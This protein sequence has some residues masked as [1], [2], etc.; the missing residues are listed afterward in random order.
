MPHP[1]SGTSYTYVAARWY[2]PD[3][4]WTVSTQRPPKLGEQTRAVIEE[5]A[6]PGKVPSLSPD[7]GLARGSA[8]AGPT[9]KPFALSGVRVV[10][11]GWMLASAGAGRYLAALG[12]EVI[13]V[14]HESRA[15]GMRFGAAACPLGGRAERQAATGTIPTP[16]QDGLNRSGSFMEINAGKLAI[17]L[18]LK[19][20]EGKRILE[21]LIRNADVVLE[22]YSP[23]TMDRMGLGYDRLREL[24]PGDHLSPAVGL[25]PARGLWSGPCLR[26]DR[27]SLQRH[28][29][30]VRLARAPSARR[31]RLL[32]S[33]LVRR[34]QHGDGG[35]RRALQAGHDGPRLSRGRVAGGG[36]HLP[37]RNRSA[38]SLGQWPPLVAI[39]QPF[40]LSTRR[41]AWGLPDARRRQLDRDRRL[42]RGTMA[43]GRHR[44]RP[45]RVARRS[46]VRRIVEPAR[47]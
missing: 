14:E 19:K 44:A 17:S 40:A 31:H 23:G 37:D 5:W 18:D 9:G 34:L 2:S 6:A 32:V 26:P 4:P 36:R 41:A 13:K 33:R 3:A 43:S 29:R 42:H 11:L 47:E 22:G 46:A 45:S 39:R 12:A 30:H 27:A 24:N 15:D 16:P 8:E 21:D 25:R 1:E 10:D 20:P 38:R 28:Q 35:A 7:C